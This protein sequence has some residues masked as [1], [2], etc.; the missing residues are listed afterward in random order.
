MR[1]P[2]LDNG[3]K[4]ARALIVLLALL[5]LP[6]APVD[7]RQDGVSP[8]KPVEQPAAPEKAEKAENDPAKP[9][10]ERV[11]TLILSQKANGL[12]NQPTRTPV[13]QDLLV[14]DGRL[15]LDDP[16]SKVVYLLQVVGDEAKVQ[17]V[18][19]DGSQYTEGENLGELQVS[20]TI[21]ER[22][23]LERLEKESEMVRRSTMKGLHLRPGLERVVT[24]E[25]P[26]ESETIHGYA[27]ERVIVKENDRV[28]IDAWI[29][30]AIDVDI[31]FF[32]FYNKLGA[33]SREVLA[34][35]QGLR[36]LPLRVSFTVV[37]AS[38]S[39]PI[40]VETIAPPLIDQVPLSDFRVPPGAQK[41]VRQELATCPI[42]GKQVEVAAGYKLGRNEDG[43]W[44]YADS[45]ECRR[46]HLKRLRE[47]IKPGRSSRD[48]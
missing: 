33:F 1:P 31:P 48:R 22:Q 46:E 3:P 41:V 5:I 10:V 32:R 24:V 30:E 35:I 28:I 8:A 27:C 13:Q 34:K 18:S 7:A 47:K 25:R 39:Y 26:G 12:P 45:E 42:C 38:L 21:A 14:T 20:R 19:F 36:G 16:Q 6:L 11:R 2:E 29:T 37:T 15:R 17:E 43:S 44:S 23:T 9:A 40:T 4:R